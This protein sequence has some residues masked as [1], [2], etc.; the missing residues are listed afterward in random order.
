M[1]TLF[2]WQQ[3]QPEGER[4]GGI[5]RKLHSLSHRIRYLVKYDVTVELGSCK[6]QHITLLPEREFGFEA[7]GQEIEPSKKMNLFF[8]SSSMVM[9]WLNPTMVIGV[10]QNGRDGNQRRIVVQT[11]II[12]IRVIR[13]LGRRFL[14]RRWFYRGGIMIITLG[15][16]RR[17]HGREEKRVATAMEGAAQSRLLRRWRTLCRGEKTKENVEEFL[18]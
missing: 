17:S 16:G 4:Q 11:D 5:G 7:L 1:T 12:G 15:G 18:T 9:A 6:R 14:V 2:V 10:N 8:I 3:Q 13:W